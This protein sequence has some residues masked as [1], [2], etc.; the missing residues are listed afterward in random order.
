M[1][2]IYCETIF[3][4][5][6]KAIFPNDGP[7]EVGWLQILDCGMNFGEGEGEGDK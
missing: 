2:M 3:L 1:R 4:S 5:K 7:K 6:E